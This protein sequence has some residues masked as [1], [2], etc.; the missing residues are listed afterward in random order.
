MEVMEAVSQGGTVKLN[1]SN[2][3]YQQS[4]LTAGTRYYID[5][6]GTLTSTPKYNPVGYAISS[7]VIRQ[8][9]PTIGYD[10]I[11]GSYNPASLPSTETYNH[12]LLVAPRMVI[13]RA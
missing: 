3:L 2:V 7:T 8:L 1:L 10:T 13:M 6:D 11:Q 4:G 9:P 12:S 5:S